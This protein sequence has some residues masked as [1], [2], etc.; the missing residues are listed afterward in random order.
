MFLEIISFYQS[1]KNIMW[2]LKKDK[3]FPF[4]KLWIHIPY[5][6]KTV[7]YIVYNHAEIA[8]T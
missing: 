5:D 3:D 8:E 7:E 1:I 6:N 4:L 2:L